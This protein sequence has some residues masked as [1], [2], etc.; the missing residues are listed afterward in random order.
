MVSQEPVKDDFFHSE[1]QYETTWHR[2]NRYDDSSYYDAPQH[3]V[4]RHNAT[5]Q[6]LAYYQSD[7]LNDEPYDSR[8]EY[9]DD[10]HSQGYRRAIFESDTSSVQYQRA[11]MLLQICTTMIK[12]TDN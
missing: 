3:R 6:D 1:D 2:S 11:C 9:I 8:D 4:S 10:T 12:Y 7:W 5:D